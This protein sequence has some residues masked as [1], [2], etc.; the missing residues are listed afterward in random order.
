MKKLTYA[1]TLMLAITMSCTLNKQQE[2]AIQP[3][4]EKESSNLRISETYCNIQQGLGIIKQGYHTNF[5]M[6][7]SGIGGPLSYRWTVIGGVITGSTTGSSITVKVNSKSTKLTVRCIVEGD[8]PCGDEKT[9]NVESS[10]GNDGNPF[11][12]VNLT[13]NELISPC[14]PMGHPYARYEYSGSVPSGTSVSWSVN[15][16]VIMLAS[17][18]QCHVRPTSVGGMTVKVT[19]SKNGYTKTFSKSTYT[20]SC[21]GGDPFPIK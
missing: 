18:N 3:I 21:S 12:N 6:V 19:L 8:V 16:G 14:Y 11:T 7:T 1:L 17:G 10:G 20:Q 4:N 5:S 2:E 9:F 15:T 13:I